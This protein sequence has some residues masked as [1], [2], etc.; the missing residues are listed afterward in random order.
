MSSTQTNTGQH[1]LPRMNKTTPVI[2]CASYVSFVSA[3]P[4]CPEFADSL[5]CAVQYQRQKRIQFS[6]FNDPTA[7]RRSTII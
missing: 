1:S 6:P 2:I 4:L 5:Y 3:A 7:T